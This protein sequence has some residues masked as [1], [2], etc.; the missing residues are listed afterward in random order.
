MPNGRRQ[1]V[2]F[3]VRQVIHCQPMRT[4]STI[5]CL[6]VLL[7]SAAPAQT[8]QPDAKTLRGGSTQYYLSLPTG[9]SADK[10]WPILVNIEGSGHAFAHSFQAFVQARGDKPFIMVTPCVSS[11]GNDPKDA[12]AVLAIVREVQQDYHGRDKFFLTGFSAGGHLTW[13]LIFTHP[14]LLAGAAPAAANYRGR[15]ISDISTSEARVHLPIHAF[16]GDK[17]SFQKYLDEQWA[18]AKKLA[19]DHG[20]QNLTRT[21][22]PGAGHN[23]F[24]N[25]V[26][27]FFS[28]LLDK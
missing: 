15:G 27:A 13:Q 12:E 22:V 2:A 17:D 16:Q 4:L 20:Y 8:T 14:E 24:P 28:T 6:A 23:A 19:E 3:A 10:T 25:E 9:W 21:M 18:D 5:V 11:N 26:V 7:V 1:Q